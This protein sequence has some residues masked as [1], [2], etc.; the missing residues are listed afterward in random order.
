MRP[1]EIIK[2]FP[3][4]CSKRLCEFVKLSDERLHRVY[5]LHIFP[6]LECFLGLRPCLNSIRALEKVGLM[7]KIGAIVKLRSFSLLSENIIT[8]SS[9]VKKNVWVV[10]KR[11]KYPDKLSTLP[12]R[13][14][15]PVILR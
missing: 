8:E 15:S 1:C 10:P 3:N 7:E 14:I 13:V 11:L 12:N 5:R 6:N 2:A 4:L 9:K